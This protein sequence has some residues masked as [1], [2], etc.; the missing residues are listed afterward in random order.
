MWKEIEECLCRWPPPSSG[1]SKTSFPKDSV[2]SPRYLLNPQPKSH[3]DQGSELCTNL[4]LTACT[5]VAQFCVETD[6][7]EGAQR[8]VAAGLR[9]MPGHDALLETQQL[10]GRRV[11]LA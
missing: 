3:Q 4:S 5:E 8:A 7:S 6:Q 11:A 2:R 1:D 10:I 9:M